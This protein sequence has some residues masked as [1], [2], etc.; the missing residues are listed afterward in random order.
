M[1]PHTLLFQS[2]LFSLLSTFAI[3]GAAESKIYKWVDENGKVHY[4][5]KPIENN[6]KEL[7][8]NSKIS[9]DRQLK[10]Q[11]DARKLINQQYKRI[12]TQLETE[13]EEKQNAQGQA[14]RQKKLIETCRQAR[15]QLE[16]LQ[17]P[18]RIYKPGK[19]GEVVFLSDEERK[20][21]QNKLVQGINKHCS[22]Q[23]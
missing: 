20:S 14:A 8:V 6:A 16:Q 18:V 2:L 3:E 21:E 17:M 7:K 11:A 22:D 4:S 12:F 23:K 19:N 13:R 5:D 9:K 15:K 10:A 1:K